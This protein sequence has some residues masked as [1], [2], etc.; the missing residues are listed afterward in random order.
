MKVSLSDLEE[1]ARSAIR[2]YGY[3]DAEGEAILRVMMY[4][5]LRGNN[6]G[7]VKLIGPGIPKKLDAS[8]IA[9]T[10]ETKLSALVDGGNNHAMIVVNHAVDIALA[11]AKEH[12]IGLVGVSQLGTSSG[13]IGFYARRLADDGLIG[14]VFAGSMPTVAAEGSYEPMFGTNPLA[15]ALPSDSS[16]VVLDMATAAMAFYGVVEAKTAGRELP[17]GVAYDKDGSPTVDPAAAMDGAL[18]TF[19]RG[20]KGSGLSLMVQ[21]LTG[22][23]VGASYVGIGDVADNWGGHLVLAIDPELLGGVD[24]MREGVDA[25]VQRVKAAKPLPGCQGV[26]APGERGDQKA[27]A[28]TLA[29]EVEVED[30]LYD[31][32]RKVGDRVS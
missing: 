31:A 21:A 3:D 5:Q 8:P 29:G 17:K 14:F 16:P 30:N 15:I 23:L 20:A 26:Y 7:V 1:A 10:K 12:G 32:L 13:A 28:S 19:D 4:A 22:P 25:M 11:K 18:R 24:V 27:E 2:S 9:T 6:Q